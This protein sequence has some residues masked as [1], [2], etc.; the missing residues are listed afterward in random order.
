MGKQ[1]VDVV[2]VVIVI[3]AGHQIPE[4]PLAGDVH[5]AAVELVE[6]QQVLSAAAALPLHLGI[7][8]L[9]E[10]VFGD[11]EEVEIDPRCSAHMER[12][13]HFC[14]SRARRSLDRPAT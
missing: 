11:Q 13:W 14:S 6:Q 8:A 7:V 10:L 5:G 3:F 9:T 4:Q 12:C 2:V 1:A